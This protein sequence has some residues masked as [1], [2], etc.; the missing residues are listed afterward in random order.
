M[1]IMKRTNKEL[2]DDVNGISTLDHKYP[3][4]KLKRGKFEVY[5]P[6]A[7]ASVEAAAVLD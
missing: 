2:L 4:A 5:G 3:H 6:S 7:I 1:Y